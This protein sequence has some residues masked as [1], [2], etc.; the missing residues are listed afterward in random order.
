[1]GVR[2]GFH[3]KLSI[4]RGGDS[5]RGGALPL[6]RAISKSQETGAV[7]SEAR[8]HYSR[9]VL[10]RPAGDSAFLDASEL[11][12]SQKD[13][14]DG[15]GSAADLGLVR[16]DG[17]IDA[18]DLRLLRNPRRAVLIFFVRSALLGNIFFPLLA[19]ESF[20]GNI[21]LGPHADEVVVTIL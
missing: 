3:E 10:R 7:V 13:H 1:M 17:E 18:V 2:F 19:P 16:R 20:G 5:R 8:L 15:S 12:P 6:L 21:G 14:L 11:Q 9:R 4:L